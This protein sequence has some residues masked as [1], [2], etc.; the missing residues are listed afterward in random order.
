MSVTVTRS[1][2]NLDSAR[3]HSPDGSTLTASDLSK[4]PVADHPP[5]ILLAGE[6]E[7]GAACVHCG[8]DIVLSDATALCS[9]CGAVHHLSCWQSLH[10]CGAYECP[11]SR[12]RVARSDLPVLSISASELAEAVPLPPAP[13][14]SFAS[15]EPIPDRP[16]N[17]LAVWAFVVA[18]LGIPLFGFV[19]GLIAIVIGCIALA[20]HSPRRR[21]LGFAVAA[22]LIGVLD[23]VGWG[24]GLSLYMSG[25]RTAVSMAELTI[26][27]DS[28]K[29]LPERI[30]R[31]MRANVLIQADFGLAGAGLGSGVV[32]RVKDDLAYIVTN[33]HVIDHRFADQASEDPVDLDDIA[34]LT[35]MTVGQSQVPASVEWVAPHGVDLAIISA[36]IGGDL[37]E[38]R[39]ARWNIDDRPHVGDPVFAVGNPHG[40][41][42]THSAG[43]VSQIRTRS[44]GLYTFKILQSTAA[45]NPGNSGGGLYDAE[46]RLIGINTM[47]GD[48]RVAEGLGF[49]IS[50]PTL[51]E[52]A[53]ESFELPATNT[54]GAVNS[55][56][57]EVGDGAE[58]AKEVLEDETDGAP[59]DAEDAGE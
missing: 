20:G 13:I 43:S 57:G 11:E 25:G 2:S 44:R 9:T 21:G 34:P 31:A 10:G 56:R 35:V 38:V 52:L 12:A 46:G 26:D 18:L 41:G 22:M 27:P 6:R 23:I 50:I 4:N 24:V 16:R 19:T 51:M 5:K 53:P 39:E 58:A 59:T 42:W 14:R 49:S 48:K 29:D 40:L 37:G 15:D 55:E 3:L 28:L 32:L 33:R 1:E 30:A 7:A 47:T 54:T 45:L 17:K 36:H 8:R